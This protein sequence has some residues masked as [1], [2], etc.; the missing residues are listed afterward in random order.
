MKHIKNIMPDVS[1]LK[2]PSKYV[3]EAPKEIVDMIE[4]GLELTMRSALLV[5][6]IEAQKKCIHDKMKEAFERT[7]TAA[8]RGK[9]TVI[10]LKD[11]KVCVF[12]V[13]GSVSGSIF[14]EKGE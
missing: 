11:G 13:D 7:E 5:E 4:Y 9:A 14:E 2:H 10:A 6:Q 8:S 3:G 12:E 1:E